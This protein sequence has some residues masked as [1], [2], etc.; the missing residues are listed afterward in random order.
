M[1]SSMKNVCNIFADI[2]SVWEKAEYYEEI[3]NRSQ[4][5]FTLIWIIFFSYIHDS[6]KNRKNIIWIKVK[7]RLEWWAT[8]IGMLPSSK[9]PISDTDLS[10]VRILKCATI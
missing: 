6:L 7:I 2:L 3:A 9:F 10:L 8:A 5:I 4:I 1:K